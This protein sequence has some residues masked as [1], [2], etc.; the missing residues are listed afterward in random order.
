MQQL[1]T[2][3]SQALLDAFPENISLKTA[4]ELLKANPFVKLCIHVNTG[5]LYNA[6]HGPC[7]NM[8]DIHKVILIFKKLSNS[9]LIGKPWLI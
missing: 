8:K 1:P 9:K 6:V 4:Q 3:T 7:K 5:L 2:S